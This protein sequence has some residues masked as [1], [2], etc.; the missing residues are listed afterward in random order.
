[1]KKKRNFK[2]FTITTLG[3]KVNQYESE[4]IA[5][6]L[7]EAGFVYQDTALPS[8]DDPADLC[9][10]NTCTVTQKASMQSRQAVRQAVRNQPDAVIIVTGCYA[11]TEPAAIRKIEGVHHIIPHREKDRIPALS[12]SLLETSTAQKTDALSPDPGDA[13]APLTF[14]W[15]AGA[16]KTRP[17]LKIQDGCDAFCSYCIVPH[18]RGNSRSMAADDV[19]AQLD[20]FREGGF[21]EVVL[22]GIHLGR[23]GQDLSPPTTLGDLLHRALGRQCVRRLRLSSIEPLELTPDIIHLTAQSDHAASQICRHFHIPLQ[24]GDDTILEKM[25]RPYRREDFKALVGAIK[26]ALPDAGIGCDVLIGFPGETDEAFEN[27]RRLIRE[28]PLTYLHVFPFSARQGTPA[29]RFPG[30]VPQQLVKERC[31]RMRELGQSKRRAFM[32]SHRGREAVVLV[33]NRRHRQTGLLKGVTSNYIS[34]LLEGGD[35]RMNTFQCVRLTGLHGNQAM[36]GS[37]V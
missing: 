28:L 17:F 8:H 15:I 13:A 33:E 27:T 5:R 6:G 7:V 22:T 2:T 31:R 23:Y 35:E 9:I 12:A 21:H 11:Q 24:S 30:K 14:S 18:A 16:N 20:R 4:Q 32:D 10:I 19:L 25:N 37:L 26:Q 1:V 29:S 34:V 3:C 36:V